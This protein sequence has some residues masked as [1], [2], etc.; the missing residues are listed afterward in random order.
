MIKVG[1]ILGFLQAEEPAIAAY[2]SAHSAGVR[3]V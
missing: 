2:E 1:Y 3:T